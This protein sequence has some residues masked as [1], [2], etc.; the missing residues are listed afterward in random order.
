MTSMAVRPRY[1]IYLSTQD[2]Q[3]RAP[4]ELFADIVE[5][6]GVAESLGFESLFMGQ[7]FVSAPVQMLQP[8]P[9]LGRLAAEV[10]KP[11]LGAGVLL[12]ALLNPVE[13]AENAAT[14]DVV[15]GGRFILC[16]GLGYREEEN[17]AFGVE[18]GRGRLLRE[19][20]DVIRRL[21]EGEVVTARG[22]GYQ[23]NGAT[24]SI[25]PTQRP[26]PPIWLGAISDAAVRR[27]VAI[28]DAWFMDPIADANQLKRQLQMVISTR[29][30]VPGEVPILR[31]V[32]VAETDEAA[33]ELAR[34]HLV[35]KYEMYARWGMID[36]FK[37]DEGQS[38][39]LVGSPQRIREQLGAFLERIPATHVVLRVQWPGVRQDA[40]LHSLEMLSDALGLHDAPT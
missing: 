32:C 26:R 12:G 18:G 30:R 37:W 27:A 31:E 39:F 33:F 11:L 34:R 25:R 10:S 5:Q 2:E 20:T 23:L 15:S 7:H 19:K 16:L 36:E 17:A 14:L 38:R 3:G 13:V 4:S 1:G 6:A 21:L 29:G 35:P 8:I 40:V 9:L 22:H 24:I 28:G